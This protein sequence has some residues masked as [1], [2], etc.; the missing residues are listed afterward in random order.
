MKTLDTLSGGGGGIGTKAG[1]DLGGKINDTLKKNDGLARFVMNALIDN[2]AELAA[3]Y[4]E[5]RD[6]RLIGELHEA[7]LIAAGPD[8][9]V[10]TR[11]EMLG[12]LR[13]MGMLNQA[14]L[15]GGLGRA[16]GKGDE[17]WFRGEFYDGV[18]LLR[19]RHPEL[20]RN[21]ILHNPDQ[22]AGG[23]MEVGG[24]EYD[25]IQEAML[26][27]RTQYGRYHR[28]INRLG[29]I[30]GRL[31]FQ[32]SQL[33]RL[34]NA[35]NQPVRY[36]SMFTNPPTAASTRQV[37][38][39]LE[40]E[41]ALQ[42]NALPEVRE[43]M[44]AAAERYCELLHPHVGN[45]AVNSHLGRQWMEPRRADQ[46]R[47]RV[48]SMLRQVLAFAERSGLDALENRH[49]DVRYRTTGDADPD[50]G[51]VEIPDPIAEDD[52]SG[53]GDGK[54]TNFQQLLENPKFFQEAQPKGSIPRRQFSKYQ[55]EVLGQSAGS[56]QGHQQS[57]EALALKGKPIPARATFASLRQYFTI[58]YAS[59]QGMN[60]LIRAVLL[61]LG[62]PDGDDVVRQIRAD[63]MNLGLVGNQDMFDLHQGGGA[64]V[65]Q[66]IVQEFGG[67]Y[68]LQVI[69]IGP[70]GGRV[71]SRDTFVVNGGGP[72]V[73]ILHM[74]AHFTPL[75]T[76]NLAAADA[77]LNSDPDIPQPNHHL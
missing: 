49:L 68:T 75:Y 69:Q 71:L 42:R 33:E 53:I 44:Q 14:G 17:K 31:I 29:D 1:S 77:W 2:L 65:L 74:G 61:A 43:A 59:G 58:G 73:T 50:A 35:G 32:R 5:Y 21:A 19:G 20:D 62:R 41:S 22:C 60:C 3:K 51:R 48:E 12:G 9:G 55:L 47:S 30:R 7:A 46:G 16:H 57:L 40:A 4:E 38:L 64:A 45:S 24:D 11:F 10:F 56:G 26:E 70:Q 72:T 37:I 6:S 76:G 54:A 34:E 52:V 36:Y 8:E 66:R 18:A 13:M 28:I 63:A 23:E 67:G 27:F 39:E 15:Q 25:S